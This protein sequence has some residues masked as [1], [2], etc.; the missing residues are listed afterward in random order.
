M[1]PLLQYLSSYLNW[2]SPNLKSA[3]FFADRG[4]KQ[5]LCGYYDKR[6]TAGLKKNIH[7]WQTFTK[8]VPN[9]S[10]YMYTTWGKR[11]QFMKE[12]FQLVDTYDQWK[13][14][15]PAPRRR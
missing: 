12:Y 11:Y 14:G 13:D 10:G 9:V 4:H 7:M 5:I 8:D 6:N 1:L 3:K 15:M 2:Y